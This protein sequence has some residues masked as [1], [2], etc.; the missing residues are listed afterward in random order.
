MWV[1]HDCCDCVTFVT[2]IV[3]QVVCYVDGSC[4]FV[5]SQASDDAGHLTDNS[6]YIEELAVLKRNLDRYWQEVDT[7]NDN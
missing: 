1:D 6:K 4:M 5:C 7:T 2:V 3:K